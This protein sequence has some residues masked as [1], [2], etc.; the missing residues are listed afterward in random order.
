MRG[1]EQSWRGYERTWEFNPFSATEWRQSF[2]RCAPF[3]VEV[4]KN[5]RTHHSLRTPNNRISWAR[6]V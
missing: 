1:N 5:V 3:L 4:L 6:M 2:D